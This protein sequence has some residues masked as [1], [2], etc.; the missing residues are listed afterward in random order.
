M[1]IGILGTGVVGQTL[2]R[3]LAE[4]G[5][6]VRM[7]ARSA[8]NEKA[9][10]WVRA[11]GPGASQGTFEDAAA[12]GEALFNCTAGSASLDALRQAGAENLRGKILI[13]V[14][15]PL[16]FS[17]GF[18]PSLT[19]CNDDSVGERIQKAFPEA[20]V[21][22]TLNTVTAALMVDPSLVPGEHVLF[23]NGNGAEAKRQVTAWL[24]EWFGWPAARIVDVGD[25]TTARGTEMYL[26]LWVRL[27]ASLGSPMFNFALMRAPA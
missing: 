2:G 10:E 5:H 4:V 6:E 19:V 11:A 21:V 25:I 13:D 27:Y 18:P 26:A 7:G 16:D 1:R 22:K 14:S 12:F 20:R 9:A 15:N 3:K 8:G 17:S 23:L 24:G